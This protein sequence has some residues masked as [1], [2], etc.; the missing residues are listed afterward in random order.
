MNIPHGHPLPLSRLRFAV[1]GVAL[2]ALFLQAQPAVAQRALAPRT[3]RP[4]VVFIITDD[5]GWADLGS[6][7]ARDIK[8]PNLDRLARQGVRFTDFYANGVSCTPTRTG[9]I[10]GRYQQRYGAEFPLAAE[11]ESR[12]AAEAEVARLTP[13]PGRSRGRGDMRPVG[14]RL[15]PG[16]K[17]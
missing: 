3:D 15:P 4:N 2:V 9:L 11:G 17:G 5:M 1:R 7:G 12:A 14:F 6:Y 16:P 8:T 13:P 10:T